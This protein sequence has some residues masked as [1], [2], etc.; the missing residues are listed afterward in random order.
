MMPRQNNYRLAC[1]VSKH[2]GF[3][4]FCSVNIK[5]KGVQRLLGFA[6]SLIE[7]NLRSFK[8]NY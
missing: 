7:T 3:S 4:L 8:M 2:R 6:S 5:N 1:T